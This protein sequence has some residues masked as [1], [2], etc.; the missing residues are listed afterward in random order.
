MVAFLYPLGN[1]QGI[2]KYVGTLLYIRTLFLSLP[3]QMP[4]SESPRLLASN[5]CWHGEGNMVS[6]AGLPIDTS[7]M[8][9][10]TTVADSDYDSYSREGDGYTVP[11]PRRLPQDVEPDRRILDSAIIKLMDKEMKQRTS[12]H[13]NVH[14]MLGK[15]LQQIC[16][17][18]KQYDLRKTSEARIKELAVHFELCCDTRGCFRPREYG[19]GCVYAS[20]CK[21]CIDRRCDCAAYGRRPI[22]ML[23][24]DKEGKFTYVFTGESVVQ[25]GGI[26]QQEESTMH[27]TKQGKLLLKIM[28][29]SLVHINYME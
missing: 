26:G 29:D 10:V 20:C 15:T 1:E 14:H 4:P 11:S 19:I 9:A 21:G 18:T 24:C 12:R 2:A 25:K 17:F 13:Y 6:V 23:T 8:E 16:S 22:V 7:H 27:L 28:L 3:L 5:R